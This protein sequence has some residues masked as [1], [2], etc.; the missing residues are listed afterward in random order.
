MLSYNGDTG[1]TLQLSKKASSQL[2]SAHWA[3]NSGQ[4]AA[5]RY[6]RYMPI[7]GQLGN[8]GMRKCGN[9]EFKLGQGPITYR[10]NHVLS[11]TIKWLSPRSCDCSLLQSVLSKPRNNHKDV[12]HAGKQSAGSPPCRSSLMLNNSEYSKQVLRNSVST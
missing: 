12:G 9:G 2:C 6:S 10:V 7:L 1:D 8:A 11:H 5:Q 4:S 3:G